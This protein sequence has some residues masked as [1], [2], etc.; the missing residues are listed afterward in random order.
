VHVV[1]GVDAAYVERPEGGTLACAAAVSLSFPAL[2]Q[3]AAHVVTAPVGFPYVP[4]LLAFR[5]IPAL[6]EAL[7]GLEVTPDVVLVDAHGY[8]H[9]R[10]FGAACHLGVLI[11]RPT[12]GCAKSRL[13]GHH[14]PLGTEFGARAPLSADG[15]TIG[16]V[17]R[18][19]PGGA[20]LFVSIGHRVSLETAVQIVL[21]CCRGASTMPEPTRRADVLSKEAARRLRLTRSETPGL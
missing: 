13:I 20:P 16:T 10:R 4:G 1:A 8:A 11:D 21:A 14:D 15:E 3:L 2:E 19:L 5:E 12:V 17:V 7:R 9:P 6:I 18:T